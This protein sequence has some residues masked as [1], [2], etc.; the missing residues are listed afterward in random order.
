MKYIY[1]STKT[2]A[3]YTWEDLSRQYTREFGYYPHNEDLLLWV[4]GL[5]RDGE[6]FQTVEEI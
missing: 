6:I 3:V 4:V 5:I 1:Y 2:D